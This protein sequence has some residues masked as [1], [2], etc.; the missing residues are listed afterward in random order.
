[1]KIIFALFFSLT[2]ASTALAADSEKIQ[3]IRKFFQ[4]SNVAETSFADIRNNAELQRRANP[5]IPDE[6]WKELLTQL[7]P[8]DY[9]ERMIPVYDK[10]F[11]HEEIKAF[12]VF[13]ESQAGKAFLKS[14]NI[15]LQ[16]SMM[17]GQAYV[18]EIGGPILKRLRER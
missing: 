17:A 9:M 3:D 5:Q 7:K 4:I 6:F 10:H 15:V 18:Q 11:S 13:F 12:I 1:M 14:Q 8:E 16:E 2:F